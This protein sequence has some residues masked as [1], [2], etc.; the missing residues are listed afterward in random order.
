MSEFRPLGVSIFLL[1]SIGFF[2]P[3]LISHIY[4]FGE[5][6][7]S[8]ATSSLVNFVNDGYNLSLIPYFTFDDFNFNPFS[9]AGSSVQDNI[10]NSVTFFGLLPDFVLY[11]YITIFIVSLFWVVIKLFPTT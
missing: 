5:I 10:A 6:Q 8:N 4:D 3:F 9:L 1:L 11:I 2:L 7:T